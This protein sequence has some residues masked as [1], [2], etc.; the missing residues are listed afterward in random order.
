MPSLAVDLGGT[1]LR[2]GVATDSR[3]V[4]HVRRIRIPSFLDG[5]R[6]GAIW[7]SIVSDIAK[8][9]DT[10]QSLGPND[11]IAFA[12]PGPVV[13]GRI[14][15]A[16]TVVG[17][18]ENIPDI[19]AELERRTGRP[20][21]LLNDVSA[22][23]WHLSRRLSDERF[24]V[25]TVS[26]GIGCKIFDRRHPAGVIDEVMHA[27]EIGH[28]MVDD[29]PD[30]PVC[31]CGARGHLGAIASGRG[32]ERLARRSAMED[33]RRFKASRCVVVSG[34][35][36]ETL[37]NER[38]LVPAIRDGDE[39][40]VEVLRRATQPLASTLASIAYGI[41][42][43]RIAVI[44]GFALAIGPTY[45]K[46]L[47]RYLTNHHAAGVPFLDAARNFVKLADVGADACLLGA[48]AYA[49]RVERSAG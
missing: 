12:F 39:W 23:A 28:C 15:A 11:P 44:G 27:G 10:A 9:A 25:L 33:P 47:A 2:C 14:L 13:G 48:V 31:D 30:A 5:V 18:D 34:A 42:L 16:P 26:S 49:E 22:A 24:M 41:G 38:H 7:E 32:V 36:A 6:P 19:A 4:E 17:A 37:D 45:E 8:Y 20:V 1:F 43:S 3:A 40:A 35:T 46:L 21:H 29:A